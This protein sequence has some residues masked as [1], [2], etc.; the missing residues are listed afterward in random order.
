MPYAS[1]TVPAVP[2]GDSK[3]PSSNAAERGPAMHANPGPDS[4]PT[5]ALALSDT[6]S[7]VA[8]AELAEVL[9]LIRQARQA[10]E[11]VSETECGE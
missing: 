9:R 8:E 2:G 7:E 11:Q 1:S 6:V 5:L 3:S 10:A 4:R